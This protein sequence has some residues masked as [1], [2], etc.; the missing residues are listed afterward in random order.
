[1][2]NFWENVHK[3][4][5]WGKYPSEIIVRFIAQ[6]FYLAPDRNSVKILEIGCGIGSNLN[7]CAKEGF[8]I[9][10]IDISKTA[11]KKCINM[12]D[13]ENIK[14]NGKISAGDLTPIKYKNNY[15]DAVIDS[16]CLTCNSLNKT[17]DIMSEIYRV[18]KPK[19][20]FI[21]VAFATDSKV[22]SLESENK[23]K[24]IKPKVGPL[25]IGQTVRLI[26]KD[27]IENL[28]KKFFDIESYEIMQRTTNN[29]KYNIVEYVVN[30]VK[31]T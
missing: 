18:I 19:G 27:D 2:T 15:F 22:G 28:Y 29:R 17:V 3:S 13:Q 4:R 24:L 6:N 26:N 8:E 21:S 10:G 9:H 23:K 25:S 7:F 16:E 20:K 14:W 5:D 30:C 1:M 11:V 12:L 31:R